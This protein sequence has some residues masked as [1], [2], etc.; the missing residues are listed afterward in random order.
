MFSYLV[1]VLLSPPPWQSLPG[2]SGPG[3]DPRQCVP[4]YWYRK[5]TTAGRFDDLTTGQSLNW[6]DNLSPLSAK[7]WKRGQLYNLRIIFII[8]DI[9]V[10][11]ATG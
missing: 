1:Y 9:G 11:V 10:P 2:H 7:K 8:I 3:F 5:P 6:P 4:M